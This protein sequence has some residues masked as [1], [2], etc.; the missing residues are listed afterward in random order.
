[1]KFA[2]EETL[3]HWKL[4]ETAEYFQTKHNA[5]HTDKLII[6]GLF[7]NSVSGVACLKQN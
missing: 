7:T 5:R 3:F 4:Y 2:C 1:M 6:M